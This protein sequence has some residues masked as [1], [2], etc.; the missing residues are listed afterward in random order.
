MKILWIT[1]KHEPFHKGGLA[2][3]SRRISKG[4][5]KSGYDLIVTIFDNGEEDKGSDELPKT[6]NFFITDKIPTEYIKLNTF[7]GDVKFKE[8]QGPAMQL[9]NNLQIIY[10]HVK[11]L[12]EQYSP[13][14]IIS[15]YP[16]PYGYPITMVANEYGRIPVILSFRGNDAERGVFHPFHFP[17][18]QY[19]VNNASGIIFV[20]KD[21]KYKIEQHLQKDVLS[22]L[23]YNGIE[24]N[25]IKYPWKEIRND[26][27]KIGCMGQNQI[28]KGLEIIVKEFSKNPYFLMRLN[29]IGAIGDNINKTLISK[30]NVSGVVEHKKAIEY[31][32]EIDIFILASYSDGCPNALLEAM[33]AGK[34]IIS[35]KAGAM[36]DILTHEENCLFF[37]IYKPESLISTINRL[38][39]DMIL[40]DRITKGAKKLALKMNHKWEIENWIKFIDK[41][42]KNNMSNK[43]FI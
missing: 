7:L 23:I 31:L 39:N 4:L 34:A 18:L 12:I 32:N 43:K 21:L 20:A 29:I 25:I 19:T 11:R 36:K 3:S 27:L 42:L 38:E 22:E 8:N 2:R 14:L 16:V 26:V 35:T 13:D 37:D 1:P 17:F 24:E 5:T 30:I 9:T 15:F 40:F 10:F 6:S 41:V 28:K 33:A